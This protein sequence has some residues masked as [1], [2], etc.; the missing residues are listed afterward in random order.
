MITSIIEH[1]S[2]KVK[3]LRQHQASLTSFFARLRAAFSTGLSRQCKLG[4]QNR[5]E[6]CEAGLAAKGFTIVELLI[7]MVVIAI[8]AA[9]TIVSYN[10]IA[11][12]AKE[13]AL[14]ADL[15]NGAKQL[16]IAKVETGSYP[17]NAND[18][19]KSN[20]TTFSYVSFDG[21]IFCLSATNSNLTG[22]AFKI[23]QAGNIEEGAC[24]SGLA[25]TMQ[26][27]TPAMCASLTTYTGAN[28]EAVMRLTD[29]R[30]GTT[31]SYQV[32][33][34][35][36]GNCWM[37]DNLKL[38]STTG[39]ITLT[40]GDSD[41]ANNFTL[42]Q[43][44]NSGVPDYDLPQTIGPVLGNDDN[45]PAKNYGYLY[46]WAAATAGETR[47]SM[48]VNS[49]DAT[50]SICPS[51]WRLPSG[52]AVTSD[53]AKLDIAFDGTG[54]YV[55]GGGS[56]SKWKYDGPFKNVFAGTWY[57]DFHHQ[58]LRGFYWSRTASSADVLLAY[59][60]TVYED[61]VY[62]GDY[63]ND[64]HDARSVRCFMHI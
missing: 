32:A 33:K 23:T 15:S 6:R 22:K 44:I 5:S 30:G 2:E 49:G 19:K 10:G 46:N 62:P 61:L 8:L 24:G 64:R 48:P 12:Q 45:D 27:F 56:L 59:Y 16:G 1:F 63:P 37:L 42:P 52:G 43:V 7:V 47:L 41:V 54:Q 11:S 26:A 13:A 40:S 39:P 34:L 4:L 3:M 36:D 31:R 58:D 17:S 9:I 25:S 18:L 51:G 20:G 55:V 35:V 28:E 57:G 53:F 21:D 50:H 38:G 60:A 14:K 29:S